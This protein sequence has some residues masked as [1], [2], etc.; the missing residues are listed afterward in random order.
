ML[1]QIICFSMLL[2]FITFEI[3]KRV[4]YYIVLKIRYSNIIIIETY[5]KKLLNFK[6]LYLP[7]FLNF[8]LT[9]IN[10][11][12]LA[13]TVCMNDQIY[14]CRYSWAYSKNTSSVPNRKH[15]FPLTS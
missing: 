6:N 14:A 8:L 15:R 9:P 1:I 2:F 10:S 4:R 3:R 7:I 11:K 13:L 5:K 12:N